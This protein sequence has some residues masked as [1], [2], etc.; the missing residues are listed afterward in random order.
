[1]EK[2]KKH[3]SEKKEETSEGATDTDPSPLRHTCNVVENHECL[4]FN[5]VPSSLHTL[6]PAVEKRT[7]PVIG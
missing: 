2:L 3:L 7:D 5:I 6:H 1:M 4:L